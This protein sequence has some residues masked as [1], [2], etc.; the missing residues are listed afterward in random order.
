MSSNT[1]K[2]IILIIGVVVISWLMSALCGISTIGFGFLNRNSSRGAEKTWTVKGSFSDIGIESKV[3][4]IRIYKARDNNTKV[5]WTGNKTMKLSV[6]NRHG[7][8][9]I[10][11]KYRLPW[12]LRIGIHTG[13]SVISVYLPKSEY[14]SLAA[15]S[16]TGSISIPA[17]FTFKSAAVETD[18]GSIEVQAKISKQLKAESDTGRITVTGVSPEKT[19]LK[20]DT[21]AIT[22]SNV[23]N[24][25]EVK[26]KTATGRIGLTDVKCGDLDVKSDTGSVTLNNVI[27]SGKITAETDT[28][29]I[30]L[31][32]CDAAELDLESDTGAIKGTLLSNKIFVTKSDTGKISVPETSSGGI[33]RIETDTGNISFEIV[34]R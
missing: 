5:T 34:S 16:D 18:T 22:L 31:D 12:F 28:G 13:S 15:E 27:A 14:D 17:G 32:R 30:S 25:S 26:V 6:N 33:C 11:E 21:G 24:S 8:L 7:K 2:I 1:K 23:R 10:G 20:S 3:S 9:I 4:D 29:S 19:D